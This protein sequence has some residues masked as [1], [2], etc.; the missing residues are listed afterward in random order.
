MFFIVRYF[1]AIYNMFMSTNQ[2]K[3][4][5][6]DRLMVE[7]SW[8]GK[9]WNAAMVLGTIALFASIIAKV[10]IEISKE[11]N[12]SPSVQAPLTPKT[13]SALKDALEEHSSDAKKSNVTI[14]E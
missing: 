11:A 7:G 6:L 8:E 12:A 14:E 9:G 3:E 10:V 4:S 2:P 5:F 1:L 13:S